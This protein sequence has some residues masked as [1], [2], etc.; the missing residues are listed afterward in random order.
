MTEGG[1]EPPVNKKEKSP[2]AMHSQ[3]DVNKVVDLIINTKLQFKEIAK[4][5]NYDHT[6]IER[7]NYGK[8]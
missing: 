7:I 1:E 3:E 8:L 4:I 6:S 5:T 2:F